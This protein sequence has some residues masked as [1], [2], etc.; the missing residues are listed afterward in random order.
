MALFYL[1][2]Y[3]RKESKNLLWVVPLSW[4]LGLAEE[5]MGRAEGSVTDWVQH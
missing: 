5:A 2:G 1:C 3:W 4:A